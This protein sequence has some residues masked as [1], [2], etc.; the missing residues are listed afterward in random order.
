[1]AIQTYSELK[2][3]IQSWA[4]RTDIVDQ[5]DT[6][7]D[8]A[9]SII[10]ANPDASLRIRDMETRA[11][12]TLSTANRYEPL[13]TNYLQMRQVKLNLDAGDLFLEYKSP[14]S[15]HISPAAGIPRYYTIGSQIELER[16]PDDDY[17]IEF[18]YYATPTPLSDA[19]PTNAV[20]TRFPLIYLYGALYAFSQWSMQEE[21]SSFYYQSF[22]KAIQG[23]NHLDKRGRY[24]SPSGRIAGVT[25]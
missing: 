4:K 13:P 7:I 8:I 22:I 2:I 6:F 11:T 19:A 12:G 23:A 15:L 9:E 21:K 16:V 24:H 17:T 3:A 10:Y 5:F 18:L 20:L 25:P 1:M 14:E